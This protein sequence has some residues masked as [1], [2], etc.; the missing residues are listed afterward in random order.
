MLHAAAV[1]DN[2]EVAKF[3]L[4]N[5]V[6]V[7]ATAYPHGKRPE[8]RTLGWT[9][10]MYAIRQ[11]NDAMTRFLLDSGALPVESYLAESPLGVALSFQAEDVF[12]IL[13][14]HGHVHLGCNNG[15][16]A[17]QQPRR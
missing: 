11:G 8:K 13:V 6:D 12:W 10:L 4:E 15:A 17:G 16:L 3:A 5:G 14:E 1:T 2:L 7:N 9:A